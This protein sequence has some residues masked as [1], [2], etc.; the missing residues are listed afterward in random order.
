M[1][2]LLLLLLGL[3]WLLLQQMQLS[4]CH[5]KPTIPSAYGQPTPMAHYDGPWSYQMAS[6][7]ID[8]DCLMCILWKCTKVRTTYISLHYISDYTLHRD[9][10]QR[11]AKPHMKLDN[12]NFMGYCTLNE[13]ISSVA[14]KNTDLI[15]WLC[16]NIWN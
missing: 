10:K 11:K 7:N 8:I 3:I 1:F 14:V 12:Q 9:H 16:R 4:I 5:T 2:G 13:V 6:T 15:I